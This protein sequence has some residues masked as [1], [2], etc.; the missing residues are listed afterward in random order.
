M[1]VRPLLYLEVSSTSA[2]SGHRHGSSCFTYTVVVSVDK[3]NFDSFVNTA[4]FYHVYLPDEN[5]PSLASQ[6]ATTH[7]PAQTAPTHHFNHSDSDFKP[8]I[9]NRDPLQRPHSRLLRMWTSQRS[10]CFFSCMVIP[11][12]ASKASLSQTP[13]LPSTPESSPL[14]AL[15]SA[16]PRPSPVALSSPS[17]LPSSLNSL[18][19]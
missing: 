7:Q 18:T 5:A 9:S 1:Q 13:P 12:R 15:A 10:S 4:I 11:A 19:T 16:S 14:T 3:L 6:R 8:L 17:L 2:Q